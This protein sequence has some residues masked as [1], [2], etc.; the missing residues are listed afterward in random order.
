MD[1]ISEEF[2]KLIIGCYDPEPE[3]RLALS[4][5]QKALENMEIQ[6]DRPE[7]TKLPGAEALALRSSPD[8]DW[9][10]VKRLLNQ[11]QVC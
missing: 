7:T 1:E 3:Q 2:W 4:E 8:I 10:C 11:I 5:I 9:D 6:D